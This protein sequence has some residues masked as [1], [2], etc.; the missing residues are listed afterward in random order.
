MDGN[1]LTGHARQL[2]DWDRVRQSKATA[3][4]IRDRR[5]RDRRVTH[6]MPPHWAGL[7]SSLTPY[8]FSSCSLARRRKVH[9]G[10]QSGTRPPFSVSARFLGPPG[11]GP[12]RDGPAEDHVPSQCSPT[13]GSPRRQGP[14]GL[15]SL[16]ASRTDPTCLPADLS[17][18]SPAGGL[19]DRPCPLGSA[20]SGLH[21]R[22]WIWKDIKCA[23]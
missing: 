19:T 7:T 5:K 10:A 6:K 8:S 20:Q 4:F 17:L 13:P 11:H 1:N 21:G 14:G 23:T 15:V 12:P 16:A 18:W 22:L 2:R 9:R 3:G